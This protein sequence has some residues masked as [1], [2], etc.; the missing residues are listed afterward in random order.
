MVTKGKFVNCLVTVFTQFMENI[1]DTGI[2]I[3][4]SVYLVD[5]FILIGIGYI[6]RKER[7][8]IQKGMSYGQC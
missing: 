5:K 7:M 1:F 4:L 8:L 6:M 3:D 2:K